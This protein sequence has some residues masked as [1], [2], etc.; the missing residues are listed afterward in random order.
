[1]L[2]VYRLS[3]DLFRMVFQTQHD[4]S[5][6]NSLVAVVIR[7]QHLLEKMYRFCSTFRVNVDQIDKLSCAADIS[8]KCDY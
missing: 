2:I 6:F 1:M 5:L 4:S 8:E 3:R 7:I